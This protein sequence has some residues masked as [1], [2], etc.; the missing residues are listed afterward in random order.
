MRAALAIV[1]VLVTTISGPAVSAAAAPTFRAPLAQ[2]GDPFVFRADGQYHLVMSDDSN[3][4][5]ISLK[6]S[7]TLSTM[8]VAPKQ[9]LFTPPAPDNKEVWGPEI[10]KL[11]GKWYLYYTATDTA[12]ADHRLHVAES[13]A[14]GGPFTYKGVL[15]PAGHSGNEIGPSILIHGG[16]TYLGFTGEVSDTANGLFLAPMSDPVTVGKA[17]RIPATGGGDGKCPKIREAQSFLNR[18]GKTWMIYSACNAMTP[19]YRLMMKSIAATANPLVAANWKQH[20]APVFARNNANAV[21]GPGS[22]AFFTSPDGAEDWIVYHAKSHAGTFF[23]PRTIRAQRFTWKSDGSPD[24]GAPKGLGVTQTLPSGDP[25]GGPAWIND[26]GRTSAG[27]TLT[28]SG[29]WNDNSGCGPQC[30]WNQDHWSA[31]PQDTATFT[32]SGT[33]IA[34]LSAG[35]P[36]SGKAMV[37]LDGGPE[38]EVDFYRGIRSGEVLHYLSPIVAPGEHTLRIRPAGTKNAASTG[39]GITIDRAEIYP[40]TQ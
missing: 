9:P 23:T 30:F 28:Y 13:A 33:R 32:F 39:Y 24:F 4:G 40:S 38:R 14:P 16:K 8:L 21:Y 12:G 34:L 7:A 35:G 18:N 19:D 2:G 3:L 10:Y 17:V 11:G 37:S 26:D 31:D 22:N 20:T 6:R 1:A 36:G 29:T 27:G 15:D 5:A 25:G